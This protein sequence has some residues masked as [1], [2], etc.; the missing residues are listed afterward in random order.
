MIQALIFLA[1]LGLFSVSVFLLSQRDWILAIMAFGFAFC[2][3]GVL[4]Q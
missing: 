4:L 1:G 3:F 2:C